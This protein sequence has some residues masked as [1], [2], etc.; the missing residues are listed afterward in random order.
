MTVEEL[1][2]LVRGHLPV[3]DQLGARVT[4]LGDG[5][6]VLTAE[7]GPAFLRPGGVVSGPALF[8]LADAALWVAVLSR[9]PDQMLAVTISL[10]IG[11]LR[12]V[13]PG[14]V[15]AEAALL[16][17]GRR[18]AFGDIRLFAADGTLSAHATG[19]YA[20]ADEAGGVRP[21]RSPS[22]STSS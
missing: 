3:L 11:F 2:R 4:G 9:R 18:V 5:K 1:D 6:A 20:L 13:P 14:A 8:A 21:S 22:S 15:R 19:S 16:R 17:L 10:N 12:P 7:I